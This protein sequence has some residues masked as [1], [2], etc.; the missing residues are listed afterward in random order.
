MTVNAAVSGQ[1]PKFSRTAFPVISKDV[2]NISGSFRLYLFNGNTFFDHPQNIPEPFHPF[3]AQYD[4]Y[5]MKYND[6]KP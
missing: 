3:M 6:I 4:T 2:G 5:L 1:G